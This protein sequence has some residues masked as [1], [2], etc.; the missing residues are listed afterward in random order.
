M[1]GYVV[2]PGGD[3]VSGL[4][5]IDKVELFTADN[6]AKDYLKRI[7]YKEVY[8]IYHVRRFRFPVAERRW[9]GQPCD[10][11]RFSRTVRPRLEPRMSKIIPCRRGGLGRDLGGG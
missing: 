10:S 8:L 3:W 2:H 6:P 7:H 4:Y 9:C 11:T 1:A 5:I